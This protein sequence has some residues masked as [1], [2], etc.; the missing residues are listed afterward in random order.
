MSVKLGAFGKQAAKGL[1]LG[2]FF[3][4]QPQ[5][6][7]LDLM[8]LMGTQV[9]RIEWAPA[10]AVLRDEHGEHTYYSLDDLSAA[11]LGEALPLE[12]L[13]QWVQG[14]PAPDLPSQAGA[15]ANTFVQA[16]WTIDTSELNAKKIVASRTGDAM[17]R[18]AIIKIYLDR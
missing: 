16:G 6:G 15:E 9:A 18:A 2:F 3:A 8:T 12:L 1:S 17:H 7:Q 10:R 14:R 13:M 11:A 4:G 5:A